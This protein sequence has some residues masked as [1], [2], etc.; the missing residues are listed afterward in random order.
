MATHTPQQAYPRERG[1]LVHFHA[2]MFD[3]DALKLALSVTQSMLV[4]FCLGT[5]LKILRWFYAERERIIPQPKEEKNVMPKKPTS[6]RGRSKTPT[7]ATKKK[8]KPVEDVPVGADKPAV[9]S[10]TKLVPEKKAVVPPIHGE[11]TAGG[12]NG[13]ISKIPSLYEGEAAHRVDDPQYSMQ[14]P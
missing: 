6:S 13:D 3:P 4:V 1:K 14:T 10:Q 2:T 8:N 9:D 7:R 5:F 11:S 12:S